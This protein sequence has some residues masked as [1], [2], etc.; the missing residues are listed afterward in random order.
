MDAKLNVES[1]ALARPAHSRAH[2][3]GGTCEAGG[4]VCP[5]PSGPTDPQGADWQPL[6]AGGAHGRRW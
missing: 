1:G 5:P 6:S 4:T 3:A 2:V